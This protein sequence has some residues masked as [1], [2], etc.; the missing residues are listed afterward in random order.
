[1]FQIWWTVFVI[2]ANVKQSFSIIPESTFF[3]KND[4]DDSTSQNNKS[5]RQSDFN[6]DASVFEGPGLF[7]DKKKDFE[8]FADDEDFSAAFRQPSGPKNVRDSPIIYGQKT[9]SAEISLEQTSSQQD[10][11]TN[12]DQ[13]SGETPEPV[14]QAPFTTPYYKDYL[15]QPILGKTN[16]YRGDNGY[17]FPPKK[18]YSVYPAYTSGFPIYSPQVTA[19]TGLQISPQTSP[20]KSPLFSALNKIVY[21]YKNYAPSNRYNQQNPLPYG[22]QYQPFVPPSMNPDVTGYYQRSESAPILYSTET[23]LPYKKEFNMPFLNQLKKSIGN[24]RS[25]DNAFFSQENPNLFAKFPSVKRPQKQFSKRPFPNDYQEFK[26]Q[27]QLHFNQNRNKESKSFKPVN[28]FERI[29]S[30]VEIIDKT[31]PIPPVGQVPK[32]GNNGRDGAEED[33]SGDNLSH[34]G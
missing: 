4:T 11:P 19:K 6:F 22:T 3:L 16:P 7:E 31:K 8:T 12:A 1:M 33:T 25:G 20:Y 29:R 5:K 23:G 13:Y 14:N 26:L 2:G 28:P 18:P 24:S 15:G 9:K 27:P 17:K 21:P 32:D 10:S 34:E 30:D